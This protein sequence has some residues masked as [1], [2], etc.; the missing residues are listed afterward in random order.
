M[1]YGVAFENSR[2]G[3]GAFCPGLD[4][5]VVVG[6]DR[7][8]ALRLMKRAFRWYIEALLEDGLPFPPQPDE[9]HVFEYFMDTEGIKKP[10]KGTTTAPLDVKRKGAK[11]ARET[12]AQKAAAR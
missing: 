6:D 1:K 8:D 9:G 12:A 7:E 2:N 3:V 11:A 10:K 5:M 4:G